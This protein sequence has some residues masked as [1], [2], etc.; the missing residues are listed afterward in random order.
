MHKYREGPDEIVVVCG[1]V[2]ELFEIFKKSLDILS[3]H[4]IL[5]IVMNRHAPIRIR[6]AGGDVLE[7][8]EYRSGLSIIAIEYR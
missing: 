2:T 5:H 3:Q 4:V 1:N 6:L 8:P 7:F